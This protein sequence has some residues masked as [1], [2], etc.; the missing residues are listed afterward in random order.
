MKTLPFLQ[1]TLKWKDFPILKPKIFSDQICLALIR[2][3]TDKS[4]IGY[5]RWNE[6]TSR[7]ETGTDRGPKK[8]R[9]E[10]GR[11]ED[12]TNEAGWCGRP[13]EL[14]SFMQWLVPYSL[15]TTMCSVFQTREVA[16]RTEGWGAKN[17]AK[18]TGRHWKP[19]AC[20]I[21][22]LLYPVSLLPSW[23]L[24]PGRRWWFH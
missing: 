21:N 4:A 11:A 18:E 10:R 3:S 13:G 20:R 17:A 5:S 12:T 6:A 14:L 9:T 24:S 22:R 2:I 8:T 19:G 15:R 1:L 23:S 16:T 7:R